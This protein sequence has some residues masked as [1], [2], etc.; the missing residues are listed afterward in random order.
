VAENDVRDTM[1]LEIAE[2]GIAAVVRREDEAWSAKAIAAETYL[3][4]E[5]RVN[6]PK[7]SVASTQP[8]PNNE[9]SRRL[10]PR[11]ALGEIGVD[12]GPVVASRL[13]EAGDGKVVLL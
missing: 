10:P 5:A 6:L 12:A 1:T 13:G 11:G 3:Q 7:Y 4:E 2:E 9:I 8:L